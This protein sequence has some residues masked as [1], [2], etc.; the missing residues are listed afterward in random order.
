VREGQIE[1]RKLVTNQAIIDAI[2]SRAPY[3]VLD[4]GCGEGWLARELASRSIS[5]IG[6]GAVGH[7]ISQAKAAGESSFRVL[8]YEEITASQLQ[9]CVDVV[10]CNFALLG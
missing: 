3:F 2:L 1:S 9:A 10:V 5:V 6:V 7:L 8:S 4:I